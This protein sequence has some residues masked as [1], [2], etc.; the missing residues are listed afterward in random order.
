MTSVKG[1]SE[2]S[3]RGTASDAVV[4]PAMGA[5][6]PGNCHTGAVHPRR[7]DLHFYKFH[8]GDYKSATAHLSNEEDLAYRRLLD[9]YYDTEQPIPLDTEWVSR[10]LRVGSDCVLSV[11]RDFFVQQED[12]WHHE[13]CESEL[14]N[15]KRLAEIARHNGSRGGRKPSGFP[16][17]SEPDAN[18]PPVVTKSQ[19]NH[20]PITT[21]QKPVTKNH[22]PVATNQGS[23]RKQAIACPP[24]VDPQVWADWVHL[25]KTKR[26]TVTQTVV[27]GARCEAEKAGM[28]FSDFLAVWCRRGSQGL[29]A[30]WLKET[31]PK[32]DKYE[33]L[34]SETQIIDME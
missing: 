10:R 23:G 17:G 31:K 11:L 30:V 25:R 18:G 14:E 26:A 2:Q 1:A 34:R 24:D 13:R 29:E 5:D 4:S 9:M 3:P 7:L 21:N 6:A 19:A 32:T 12:G 33:W 27:D 28:S 15:Y 22:E 20:K 16:S 8:I